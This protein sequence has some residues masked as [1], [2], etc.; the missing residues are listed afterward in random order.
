M[1]AG[2][3]LNSNFF[4]VIGMF[5]SMKIGGKLTAGFAAVL[6]IFALSGLF[7][8]NSM[9]RAGAGME[10]I[11]NSHVP[12]VELAGSIE[13]LT[14]SLMLN[15][16]T[17]VLGDSYQDLQN[18]LQGFED[19]NEALEEA[20][21]HAEAYPGL[22]RLAEGV[23]KATEQT[24][25]YR[26]LLGESQGIIAAM[27]GQRRYAAEVG[28]SLRNTVYDL[29]YD[30]RDGLEK[31]L[32][33]NDPTED[34]KG[35]F[36]NLDLLFL[37]AET[38]Q[39]AE[40]LSLTAMGEKKM[41]AVAE[42]KRE[43]ED[44]AEY[45]DDLAETTKNEKMLRGIA[46]AG[47]DVKGYKEALDA[48]RAAWEE[49]ER[50]SEERSAAGDAVIAAA[51]A[52]M[53]HSLDGTVEIT[54]AVTREASE[55]SRILLVSVASAILVGMAVAA[56]ITRMIARPLGRAVVLA[57]RA[58][59]GDLT[60]VREDFRYR[61]TDEVGALADALAGMA[62]SQSEALREIVAASEG[63]ARGADVLAD[64]SRGTNASMEEVRDALE[65]VASISET[66]SAALEESNAG[67][68]EVAAGAQAAAKATEEGV[69]A[70]NDTALMARG[71]VSAVDDV[72]RDVRT[73]G[74]KSDESRDKIVSLADS[75]ENI[76]GFV[77]II[78][79]IA[80][81]TNL[82]ALNAAIEAA[83][84]GEA[85]RGFAVVADEVRK[86]AEDSN[87]AA[88]EVASLVGDLHENARQSVA[89]AEET[90]KVMAS[91][92]EKA[93]DAQERLSGVLSSIGGIESSIV[94]IADLSRSQAS[95]GEEMAEAIDQVSHA[96]VDV[97][98]RVDAIRAAS[99]E[100]ESASEGVAKEAASMA[101][102]AD[103][104]RT[105][106]S[107]FTLSKGEDEV[108]G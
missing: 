38:A 52:I 62:A 82:L 13:R 85:G 60:V 53:K 83:R 39:K 8:W 45:L 75:V 31:V 91:V 25:L 6:V 54:G 22:E 103:H 76:S 37:L 61:G 84:A 48:F 99:G 92:V 32:K 43:L 87:R 106:L 90:G 26:E 97:V 65:Q 105:L 79:S 70:A 98:Q 41:E 81:Q 4:G 102:M 14:H 29:L 68:Q 42:A 46:R 2:T 51:E 10:T 27:A 5:R 9:N 47:E 19:L 100:T 21:G 24:G 67:V 15:V 56:V 7:A 18:A 17:Y 72:I 89:V 30:E 95:A 86:L 28:L 59:G 49:L 55:V 35:R 57:E 108:A 63:V 69:K 12:G 16:R 101:A 107:R 94:R 80:D 3:F 96:T 20:A 34:G 73:V 1:A 11:G 23:K 58:G 77:S 88:Q 104:M 66:N 36:D 40:Y 44:V 78:T 74:A 64:L 33:K 71:A 50:V 93:A